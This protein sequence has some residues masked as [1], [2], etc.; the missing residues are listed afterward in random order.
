MG[1]VTPDRSCLPRQIPDEV[2]NELF[3]RLGSH[4]DRALVAFW[5]STG[6]RASELLGVSC[7]GADPGQQ[8]I[9]HRV[10]ADMVSRPVAA[11]QAAGPV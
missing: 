4:R 10:A 3:A 6:A 11:R 7:S 8:L 5:L 1:A 9:G 2:F